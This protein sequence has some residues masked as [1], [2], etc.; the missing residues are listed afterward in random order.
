MKEWGG[1]ATG[2]GHI[3]HGHVRHPGAEHR[4]N[5]SRINDCHDTAEDGAAMRTCDDSVMRSA[6]VVGVA[7][8]GDLRI[9][10]LW[11]DCGRC[12]R[13]ARLK[14]KRQCQQQRKEQPKDDAWPL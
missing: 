9:D 3:D 4:S 6:I 7:A 5:G 14:E 1:K 10:A 12:D 8:G 2:R 11:S 13:M